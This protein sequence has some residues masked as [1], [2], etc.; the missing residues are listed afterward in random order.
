M[1]ATITDAAPAGAPDA[2]CAGGRRP[3]S[4]HPHGSPATPKAGP[5]TGRP[6]RPSSTASPPERSSG[7]RRKP[8]REPP[9]STQP[10]RSPAM[11]DLTRRDLVVKG[12][13]ALAAYAVLHSSGAAGAFPTRPGEVVIPWADQPPPLDDPTV[14]SAARLGGRSTP[15]SRPTSEFFRVTH[16][17]WPEIDASDV[18]ARDRRA[19]APSPDAHARRPQGAAARWEQVGDAG[20]LGQ[21]RLPRL[22]R[23][24]RQRPLG[25]APPSRRSSRRPGSSTTAS[26]SCSGAPTRAPSS[27]TTP[28]ATSP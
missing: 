18:D 11:L 1:V 7:A 27:C 4:V 15:G 12:S 9:R 23:R 26:R 8:R 5:P 21:P 19:G 10:T 16:F 3:R 28:S 17:D 13:A 24:R 22:H 20:V 14:L 2:P 6:W 25:R